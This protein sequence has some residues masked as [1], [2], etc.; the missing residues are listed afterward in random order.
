MV[1]PSV[2]GHKNFHPGIDV[3]N[4]AGGNYPALAT[5]DGYV[6]ECSIQNA[7]GSNSAGVPE[8]GYSVVILHGDAKY[9]ICSRYLDIQPIPGLLH[10][11]VKKGQIIGYPM[12]SANESGIHIHYQIGYGATILGS[13]GNLSYGYNQSGASHTVDGG[14]GYVSAAGYNSGIFIDPQTVLRK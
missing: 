1:P 13:G 7:G 6:I 8:N 10:T 12:I 11:N 4:S 5:A 3:V 9:G 14:N 2:S